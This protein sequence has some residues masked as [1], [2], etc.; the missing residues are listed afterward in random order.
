MELKDKMVIDVEDKIQV[1]NRFTDILTNKEFTKPTSIKEIE[2]KV[3][4]EQVDK[5]FYNV[6]VNYL[7]SEIMFSIAFLK[8]SFK[9]ESEILNKFYL[10]NIDKVYKRKFSIEG[11]DIV[12]TEVGFLQKNRDELLNSEQFKNIKEFL[13]KSS[14]L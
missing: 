12:E 14:S 10:D 1:F 6:E 3:L 5:T 7:F 4:A 13:E 2:E 11:D 8:R 9:V